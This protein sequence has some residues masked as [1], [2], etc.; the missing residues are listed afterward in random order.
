MAKHGLA[1]NWPEAGSAGGAL[2]ERDP[3]ADEQREDLSDLAFVSIDA[4]RTQDIDDALYAEVTSDGWLLY[5]AI[6]DPTP[7]SRRL[8]AARVV[9]RRASSVY[10]HGAVA[11]MLPEAMA[12]ERCA[13]A[14]NELRPALV[15]RVAGQRGRHRRRLPLSRGEGSAPA[16]SCPT[17]PSTATSAATTNR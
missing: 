9:R 14:E 8:A 4:A 2:A 11:P 10:F 12:Q 6:A 7:T 15:C 1:P 3:T 16:P 17:T 5:V 13:L